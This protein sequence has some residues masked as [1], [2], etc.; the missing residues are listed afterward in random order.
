ML[1][2]V[3]RAASMRRRDFLQVGLLGLGGL[4]LAD[5]LRARAAAAE[6]ATNR[7]DTSVVLLFLTGGA[8]H[9]E[10]FD[11]K[12]SAPAEY[13][14]ITGATPTTLPGVAF[15]GTF[16][17]LA[18]LAGQMAVVRSFTHETSD[19]T[20]AVQQVMRGNNTGQAGMGAILAR[21][22]GPSHPTT[23]SPT[24]VYLSET[25][26]DAQFDKERQRLL[27]AAGPGQLGGAYAPFP[28]GFNSPTSRDLHLNISRRRLEDRRAMRHAFDQI[29][30]AVDTSG[31][32]ETLDRFER[33]AYE[34]L[35]GRSRGAFDLAREDRRV[36]ESYDTS[37]F[38]TGLK[39]YRGSS[40]GHQ[41]LLARRLC[42]A[43]CGFITIHNPGWDMHGG[44]TQLDM[45]HGM[46]ELG[47]P[48]DHA[49]AAFL[50]DVHQRGLSDKILLVITGEFGR[51]PRINASA[52]RDHW[53]QLSTLALA[54][55]G[56]RM[57][58]VVGQSTARAEVPR[59]DPVTIE[60][61][62]AT[63]MHV[64]LDDNAQRR[65]PLLPGAVAATVA[66]ARPIRQLI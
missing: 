27:E 30:R 45:R 12:M 22:R 54:G 34:V 59:A 29:A 64:L 13:R 5:L 10:I 56:L 2:P 47:R 49:V 42:E 44:T 17:R 15:G 21:L 31:S 60:N 39:E 66:S 7:R 28:L 24:H 1:K 20:R 43:G 4:G 38:R 55:G 11:P 16:P 9:I 53:P 41:L 8:S 35:V 62:L 61:L 14:S 6:R 65:L 50:E 37:R 57:G 58:Q 3:L 46:E 33:Q 48:V 26:I 25:E 52:G 23:G 63:V 40:L 32:L 18:R 19:H 51:T 36:V